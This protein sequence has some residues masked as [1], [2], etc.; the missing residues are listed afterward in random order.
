MFKSTAI[1]I[2]CR[3]TPSSR[4]E[5][6]MAYPLCSKSYSVSVDQCV[7]ASPAMW[8]FLSFRVLVKRFNLWSESSGVWIFRTFQVAMFKYVEYFFGQ[9]KPSPLQMTRT[10]DSTFFTFI[11]IFVIN[12]IRKLLGYSLITV[13][14]NAVISSDDVIRL[15]LNFFVAN[16]F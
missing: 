10:E 1:A 15:T 2:R 9:I 12:I 11:G 8:I 6:N 13:Y 16:H 4:P 7:S 14:L 3:F 5:W